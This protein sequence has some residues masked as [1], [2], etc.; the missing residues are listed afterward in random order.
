MDET[1]IR[2]GIAT[3]VTFYSL[4]IV[5]LFI[6]YIKGQGTA[7]SNLTSEIFKQLAEVV[8]NMFRV[9]NEHHEQS[10][11]ITTTMKAVNRELAE[12]V[13]ENG[14]LREELRLGLGRQVPM[15]ANL[16]QMSQ[17]VGAIRGDIHVINSNIDI[18]KEQI[19][20]PPNLAGGS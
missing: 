14:K 7:S 17:D 3:V 19:K 4:K 15:A 12:Y 10:L 6:D 9:L 2:A 5:L 8:D 16:A 18:I 13:N 20:N 1:L 11:Q